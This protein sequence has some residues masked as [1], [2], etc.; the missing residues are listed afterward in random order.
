MTYIDQWLGL[1][2]YTARLVAENINLVVYEQLVPLK[3]DSSLRVG[4]ANLK[5][6]YI[7][8]IYYI[9]IMILLNIHSYLHNY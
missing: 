8:M 2:L 1:V 5:N 4:F 6:M 3:L 9:F 7:H